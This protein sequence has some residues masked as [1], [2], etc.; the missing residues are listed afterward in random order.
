M[1]GAFFS[2]T[3]AVRRRREPRLVGHAGIG[4]S[5]EL[6]AQFAQPCAVH[7]VW[8]TPGEPPNASSRMVMTLSMS[9]HSRIP[10]SLL[11]ATTT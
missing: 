8:R 3:G 9:E 4:A 1:P 2:T 10:E 7:V 5:A 11:T 6:E